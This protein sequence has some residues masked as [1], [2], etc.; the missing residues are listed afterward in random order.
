VFYTG[1]E[2]GES[3]RTSLTSRA[4]GHCMCHG[5]RQYTLYH[6]CSS[7]PFCTSCHTR[8][9]C[10]ELC[11]YESPYQ[12]ECPVRGPVL[13][14]LTVVAVSLLL[15]G[16]AAMVVGTTVGVVTTVAV[17]TVK[18]P[19]KVAGAV[20]DVAADDENDWLVDLIFQNGQYF[21]FTRLLA[22]TGL[23]KMSVVLRSTA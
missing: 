7:S 1:G 13:K 23:Y 12:A 17:E 5:F 2:A 10:Q 15:Q 14:T 9:P 6:T 16:C 4:M 11:L 22:D 18:V 19:F 3:E 21:S 8:I 20:I